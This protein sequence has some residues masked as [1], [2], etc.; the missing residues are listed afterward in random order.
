M[1]IRV[2]TPN[3][4][5]FDRLAVEWEYEDLAAYDKAWTEWQARSETAE[6]FEKWHQLTENGGTNEIWDLE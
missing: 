4:A 3:I 5:P 6:F 1:S 2:Y